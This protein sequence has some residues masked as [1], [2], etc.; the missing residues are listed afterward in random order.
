M[1]VASLRCMPDQAGAKARCKTARAVVG[2]YYERDGAGQPP[3]YFA[4]RS[5]SSRS[6]SWRALSRCMNAV[7][8]RRASMCSSIA[9]R[10]VSVTVLLRANTVIA[11]YL[12][13]HHHGRYYALG[14]NLMREVCRAYDRALEDVDILVMPTM[15][16]KAPRLPGPDDDRLARI[17]ATQHLI[18][19][20]APFCGTWHPAVSAPPRSS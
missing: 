18:A 1:E 15:P 12:R 3:S 6:R 10:T 16:T 7:S 20:T 8:F 19:N 4:S 5:N 13:R 2:E 17:L 11:D 9:A 14:Q